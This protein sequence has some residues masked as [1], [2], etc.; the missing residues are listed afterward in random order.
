MGP[1]TGA[2]GSERGR[3]QPTE[4]RTYIYIYIYI[5]I[6]VVVVVVVVVVGV[7]VVV[8]GGWVVVVVGIISEYTPI[9]RYT[10]ISG[11]PRFRG[12]LRNNPN[13]IPK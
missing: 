8:V 3:G 1:R 7:V 13:L 10:P 9:P 6:V 2:A 11:Q 12:I 5:D 4:I